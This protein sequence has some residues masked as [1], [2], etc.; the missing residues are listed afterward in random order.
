MSESKFTSSNC[1]QITILSPV[2]V[3]LVH[4]QFAENIQSLEEILKPHM[5]T[6]WRCESHIGQNLAECETPQ[7]CSLQ[8]DSL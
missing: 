4:R 5:L 6:A 1:D 8:M 2:G 7:T 3:F